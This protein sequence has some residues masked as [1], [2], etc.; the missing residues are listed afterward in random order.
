ELLFELTKIFPNATLHLIHLPQKHEVAQRR[1]ETTITSSLLKEHNIHYFPALE[2]CD[3]N[4]QMFHLHDS[5]PNKEGY[6]SILECVS[7]YLLN[8]LPIGGP[9]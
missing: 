9:R 8:T 7:H 4:E 3:W 5:H 1:Y 2:R 6:K